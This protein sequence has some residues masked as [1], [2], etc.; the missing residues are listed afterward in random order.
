MVKF[1]QTD[2]GFFDERNF[3]RQQLESLLGPK[4]GLS[5]MANTG[6]VLVE[7]PAL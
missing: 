5:L 7:E 6:T 1:T 4:S 3:S 2:G